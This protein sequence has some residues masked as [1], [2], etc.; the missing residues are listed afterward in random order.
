M[1][2]NHDYIQEYINN[3]YE[4]IKK[5][6]KKEYRKIE[7]S[8][9]DED[10]FH[11]TLIKCI[12]IFKNKETFDDNEFKAYLTASF[13]TNVIRDKQYHVNSMKSDVNIE[14]ID[15]NA[16]YK[17]NIDFSLVIEDIKITFGYENYEKF[18]DWLENKSIQEINETYNCKNSRY[19]IDKIRNYIKN[20]YN[21]EFLN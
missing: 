15:N 18:M 10:I 1:K 2:T 9:F 14:N 12:D 7:S 21:N 17:D 13:K 3:Q 19:I 6:L 5:M 16:I 11:E 8:E 4:N 20:E